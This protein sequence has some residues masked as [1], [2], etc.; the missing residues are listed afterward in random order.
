M[1]FSFQSLALR[2]HPLYLVFPA[3]LACSMAFHLPVST[4]PNALVAGYAHIRSKDMAIAGIGPTII[5]IVVLFVFCQTWAMVIYPNLDTFPEW[6]QIAA[7]EA[8]NKT[9]LLAEIA[10]NK[11]HMLELAANATR[12]L[13]NNTELLTDLAAN[14]TNLVG[15]LITSTTAPLAQLAV[16]GTTVLSNLAVNATTL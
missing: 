9:R 1:Y 4:P 12:V 15:N 13:T 10:A 2:I 16:N 8:A 6:A 5:T 11:T 7:E 14:S 3:G